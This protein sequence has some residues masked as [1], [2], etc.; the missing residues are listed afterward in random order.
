MNED[1]EIELVWG[2]RV[3]DDACDLRNCDI[4]LSSP[5]PPLASLPI[6]PECEC[7][8]GKSVR[9][10]ETIGRSRFEVSAGGTTA[11]EAE[12]TP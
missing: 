12:G 2:D 7:C 1:E 5:P 11:A 8:L 10:G 9:M 4:R 3:V 6:L